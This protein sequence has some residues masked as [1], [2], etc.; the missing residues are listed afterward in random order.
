MGPSGFLHTCEI[1][2]AHAQVAR[3]SFELAG[4]SGQVK[5]HIGPALKT[6]PRLAGEGP[7]DLCFIDADK[8]SYPAYLEWAASALRVGGM[9]LADNTFGWNRIADPPSGEGAE[10]IRA[11]QAFNLAIARGDRFRATILPTAEGLTMGIKLP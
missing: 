4:V 1:S 2:E 9:V 7:F 8:E 11:L 5:V 6:L 10:G 3:R